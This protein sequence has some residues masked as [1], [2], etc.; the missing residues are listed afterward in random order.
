VRVLDDEATVRINHAPDRRGDTMASVRIAGGAAAKLNLKM[1]EK[2]LDPPGISVL[3]G[4]TADSARKQM[5]DAFPKATNLHKQAETVGSA[6]VKDIREA[7]F[8]VIYDPTRNFPNH[9]RL[10]HPEG[11]GGFTQE[12]FE[13]L[14]K[15]FN[16]PILGPFL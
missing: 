9:G 3:Q 11:V 16:N 15:A 5:V 6:T 1:A 14:S 10:I 12:E 13:K 8:D 4:G 2:L 7:G